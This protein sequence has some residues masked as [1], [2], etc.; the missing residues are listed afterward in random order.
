MNTIP[1]EKTSA[2]PVVDG[3]PSQFVDQQPTSG[4]T[5]PDN[6]SPPMPHGF[7][8]NT[9]LSG[10]NE[11]SNMS[12]DSS[13]AGS[14]PDFMLD[15]SQMQMPIGYDGMVQPHMLMN[16]T[17]LRFDPN[18]PLAPHNDGMLTIMP[19]V[20]NGMAPL[21]T[22]LETPKMERAFS[23]LELGSSAAAFHPNR[24]ASMHSMA[25][26]HTPPTDQN[27]EMPAIIASQDA[28]SVFRCT[29]I[30]PSTAC[31][32][33][34]RLNLERLE[35]TL[36]NHE[37]WSTWSPHW[38]EDDM[39]GGDHLTVMQLHEST[40]DKLLAIT[41]SFLHKA[42][43]IHRDV[44]THHHHHHHHTPGSGHHSPNSYGSNFGG[45]RRWIAR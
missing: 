39:A 9:P 27:G 43:E 4:P 23:D 13:D 33:T 14:S 28:W 21:I 41:Q 10:Y 34:A 26:V 45:N 15:W 8:N 18:L 35:E 37:G 5:P 36:R 44:N 24:H 40:R 12:K 1:E 38:H 32:K 20:A 31:P 17:D 29:P 7:I 22:P 2:P 25:S 19:D 11:F 6:F 42:L 30:M 3:P 16:T